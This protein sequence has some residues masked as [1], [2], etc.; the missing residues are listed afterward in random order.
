MERIRSRRILS[1]SV[2]AL[3]ALCVLPAAAHQLREPSDMPAVL[4]LSMQSSG[5]LTYSAERVVEF[6]RG[7]ER[8]RHMEL[9]LRSGNKLRLEFPTGS[10]L[11]GQIVVE[12]GKQ[13]LHYFPDKDEIH[14]M[15]TRSSD[16]R[17]RMMLFGRGP[18]GGIK[19]T[20]VDG[21]EIASVPSTLVS[22]T[23]DQGNKLQR[24]W[25]DPKTGLVLKREVF[26][27]VGTRVGYT[28]ITRLNY[29]PRIAPGDFTIQRRGAKVLQP[30]DLARRNAAVAGVRLVTIPGEFGYRLDSSRVRKSED[31]TVLEQ[32]YTSKNGALSLFQYVG[33]NTRDRGH[34]PSRG[35]FQNV[36]WEANGQ[37]FSL[38]GRVPADRLRTI[39][40]KLGAP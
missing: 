38:V 6:K 25:I 8:E 37:R 21:D 14:V 5:K 26:D 27:R 28:A 16:G 1:R 3:A 17:N 31:A 20:V 19:Y 30:I 22:V 23:D 29:K 33:K 12:D 2:T 24:M 13:R 36:S 9:I 15:P 10:K 39:A 18:K 4:K 32:F 35:E 7:V 40:R 11:S 34:R